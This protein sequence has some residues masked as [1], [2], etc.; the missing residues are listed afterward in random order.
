MYMLVDDARR[1]PDQPRFSRAGVGWVRVAPLIHL[2]RTAPYLHNGSVPTLAALLMPPG[3]RPPRFPVGRPEQQFTLDTTL[4][5]NY[6]GGH[7]FGTQLTPAEK[8]ALLRF[9][10]SLP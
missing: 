8:E 4:P 5:G 3:E 2:A 7:D 6:N 9:L 1:A 10:E